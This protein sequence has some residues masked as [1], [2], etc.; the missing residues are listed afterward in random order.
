MLKNRIKQ[1]IKNILRHCGLEVT[2]LANSPMHTLL[3]LRN[4]SITSIIDIGANT[5]QFAKYIH[6]TYPQA[7]LYC[8]EP[9]PNAFSEL[10]TWAQSITKIEVHTFNLAIS[11]SEGV[12]PMYLHSE[13]SAS[14]SLLKTTE[15]TNSLYP[16]TRAQEKINIQASTLDNV[17]SEKISILSGETLIKL[18]VQGYEDR[19]IRGGMETLK[20]CHACIIEINLDSLYS[21]Q[22]NFLDIF[23][24]L[25]DIG[26]SYAGNLSQSYGSDG[27]VIYFDAIFVRKLGFQTD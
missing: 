20:N 14:S 16:F 26:F 8:F 10:E 2:L 13:H 4:H 5:G 22:G 9:L 25:G 6:R 18:D 11:D 7:T 3:G 24:M 15:L 12:M 19:V 23:T 21:D 27:H 17:F 1:S